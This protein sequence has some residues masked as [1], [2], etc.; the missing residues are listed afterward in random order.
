MMG[1][2][3]P[4]NDVVVL[5][6]S[7]AD[8]R[9]SGRIPIGT[10]KRSQRSLLHRRSLMSYSSVREALVGSVAW[11]FPPV[12]FQI[13]QLSIVP[14]H[15]RPLRATKAISGRLSRYSSLVAEKYGSGLTP[16][17]EASQP[18]RSLSSAHRSVVRRS[19][20]TI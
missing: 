14:A 12:S 16:V 5:P 6:K 3:L 9:T 13:S 4:K 15:K 18:A 7:P 10:E 2:D 11:T 19:C 17:R 20:Q 8:G 1:I